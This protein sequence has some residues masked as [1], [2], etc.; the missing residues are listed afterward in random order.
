M[1]AEKVFL[2]FINTFCTFNVQMMSLTKSFLTS[3]LLAFL[4]FP[5]LVIGQKKS[6]VVSDAGIT[7]NIDSLNA[8]YA[9]GSNKQLPS[10]LSCPSTNTISCPYNQNN[11]QRG[12]MFD[13][14]AITCITIKCF[15]SNFATGTTGVEIWYRPGTHVGFANSSAGWTLI[16]TAAAVTGAGSN[17]VT[18]IPITVNVT[19]NAGATAGFYITRTNASG[20]VIQYT[21]GTAVG[22]II[23]SDAN[24]QVK[25]GTGKDYPFGAS[26]TPRRF[27]GTVFYDVGTST[28]TV[29]PVSG[30]SPVCSGSVQ[31]FSLAPIA[32]ATGYNWTVPAGSTITAGANTNAITVTMGSTS[33]NV[34]VT[35]VVPCGIVT[36]SCFSVT[37]NTTTTVT[38][39][40]TPS[41][42]CAGSSSQLNVAAG[43]SY[44]WTP[45][46]GLS[47]TNCANPVAT[48][49]ASTV[50]SVTVNSSGCISTG[51]VAVNVVSNP[52]PTAGNG[53]PYCSGSTIG[54]SS[55][56]GTT[57]S[58]SG[59]L[60]FTSTSQNPTIGSSTTLMSGIYT[61]TASIGTC[62]ATATTSVTVNPTPTVTVNS[63]T[64]CATSSVTLNAMGATT[65]TWSPATGLSSTNGSSV[66]ANPAGSTT[67]TISGTSA[68]CTATTTAA[69]T[70]NPLP[71]ITV[72]S[73]TLCN[74]GS[75]TLNAN[76]ASTYTWSPGT[77]L[78]STNGSS[79]TANPAS[80]AQYTISG[81]D[82]NGCINNGTAT[83]TVVSNPTVTVNT[84][85]ICLG[86]QTATLTANGASTYV[87][88]PA[89]GLSSTTASV[90]TGTP[91]TTTAYTVTGTVGTCTTTATTTITVN[92]L[93]MVTVN[94]ATIC[95]GQQ[96]A[97]LTANG[98]NTYSWNPGTGLSG[99][100]GAT[101][102]GTPA[103]TTNYTVTG[104]DGN[105]CFNTATT[106]ILVNT[107]PNVTVNSGLICQGNS[108]NL[109]ANG[110][111]TY[112]WSPGTGLSGTTG[113]SVTANPSA[114]ITYTV[115]GTDA[116]GCTNNGTATVTVV[117][118][119]T[120]SVNSATICSGSSA[121]LS[122]NGATNYTWS[123]GTGL[124]STN[125]ASVSAN[126]GATTA[127][128]ITGTVGTCSASNTCTVTVNPLPTVS[129]G[130]SAPVCVNQNL[131]LSSS[132]GVSYSW[133]GPNAFASA[134]QSP[135]ISGVTT[136]NGG[137]Y[138]VTVTDAN[139]CVNTG[140]VSVVVNSLP[141]V[142]ASGATVCV[143][144]TINL[145]CNNSGIVFSWSGPNGFSS[146]QQNPVIPTAASNMIGNYIV[147]VT[148]ANGC[149]NAGVANV[150]VNPL[151]VI[152]ASSNSPVCN[153][154]M[155]NLSASSAANWSWTGPGGFSSISQN[156]AISN[157]TSSANGTYTVVATD[158]NGCAGNTTVMVV[159]NPGPVF[160]IVPPIASGCAPLCVNFSSTASAAYN[161]SWA[162]GD[163]SNSSACQSS[164]CYTGAGIF[165]ATLTVTDTSG[166][167]GSSTASINVYPVPQADFAW[168]PQPASIFNSAVQFNDITTGST[169]SNWA[170]TFGDV[171]NNTSS[172]Q[173]PAFNYENS[174]SYPVTLVATS[175][176]G[177]ID[178]V[179]KTVVVDP[180]FILYVPN[181]FS[182]NSDGLNDVFK[183]VGEGINEFELFVFDRW[184]N[185]L[186]HS[187]DISK[188]WDG[189]NAKGDVV[190]EDI[191]V[192]K[193]ELRTFKK[194][195]KQ[196]KGTVS[197]LK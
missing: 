111:S 155:L 66:T 85:S 6:M 156:P 35:P 186:F 180:E 78:S 150:F 30:N 60:S 2:P 119:P 24:I 82:V 29:G 96:T 25:D 37:I 103:N 157:A 179:T 62:S 70:V 172:V 116:N 84:A 149:A 158:N 11:G 117:S 89:T 1:S 7:I 140:T 77:G 90:V 49:T 17:L 48:P 14:T 112:A 170:W 74:G 23:S 59:P 8:A 93:P 99:T 181:A 153:N 144:Q 44:T 133:S 142:L 174:G 139:T 34:C 79:V 152:S 52:S 63:A 21:N 58:W 113:A 31:T 15:E 97:T 164:H 91:G 76:G 121:T 193:I 114:T 185:M 105:G 197:L 42:V 40:A 86:Q 47:C 115:T 57:Y 171:N 141:V 72:N 176:Y 191:Y 20:P 154:T 19:I 75:T 177:C 189:V 135:S 38:P 192:W 22:A 123:P 80:T 18:A 68:V 122:A 131:S 5:S 194:E 143:N 71:T 36:P 167:I 168:S 50:Y 43:T 132:G 183:A 137:V 28:V 4:F 127:Y 134:Q 81:T 10:T 27:N 73:A 128:T 102:T 87:W 88:S 166:C 145:S 39:A 13:I 51:T 92:P 160:T 196:V 136:S 65:Y 94:T 41:V 9:N 125:G 120:V 55:S 175:D 159:V 148:D 16:G 54:L 95:V 130:S 110:A 108:L 32:G 100:S 3:L 151:P 118:N 124:S 162:F 169:I 104:T 195:P 129:A 161:C 53:G 101:V 173:N 138:T 147:T 56:G 146:N 45:S 33:G 64:I 61:V 109:N 83:V 184:G 106:S 178:S 69:V 12:I 165:V 163:G 188:G 107:L 98:A 187:H 67:Y 46:A 26:F 182:P 126:P 190:Q